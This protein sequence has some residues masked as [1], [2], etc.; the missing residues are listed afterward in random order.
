V[1]PE[2]PKIVAHRLTGSEAFTDSDRDLGFDVQSFW[3]WSSSDLVS[4]AMRGVL[5]E[6]LVAQA[7]GVAEESIR[8]EW[9][10]YDLTAPDGT[11]V[12][13]KS[14]SYIQTWYQ[15]DYSRISFNV[16]KTLGWD[17]ETGRESVEPKRQADVYV[18]C[19]L[20]HRDQSTINPRDVSQWK[21]Y[22]LPTSVLD[23]RE[24]SQHSIALNSLEA[25]CPAVPY[26]ELAKAVQDAARS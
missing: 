2:L 10:P 3:R 13:V 6:F 25:L 23:G 4:N 22:V 16:P 19:L 20:Y 26:G 21:F 5:S 14:A 11:K 12:E 17:A 7:L 15:R 18:F 1:A 9:D 24:R 8:Q